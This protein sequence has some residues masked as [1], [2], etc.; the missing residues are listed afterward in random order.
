MMPARDRR[1]GRFALVG[2]VAVVIV[3][4][5]F[6]QAAPGDLDPTF[7]GDGKVT[8][9]FIFTDE[10]RGVAIQPDDFALARYNID[11]SL[12]AVFGGGDGKVKT[13][14]GSGSAANGVTLQQDGKIVAGG[15]SGTDFALARYKVCRVSSR[16]SSIPCR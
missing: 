4:P 9:S 8:T 11:G 14:F 6:A 1:R 2:A 16:R 5:T 15:L 7:E 13:D 12:D 10:A 3:T